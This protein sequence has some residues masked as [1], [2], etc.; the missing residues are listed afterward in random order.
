MKILAYLLLFVLTNYT[1]YSQE[2]SGSFES[3]DKRNLKA[4]EYYKFGNE[5]LYDGDYKGAIIYYDEAIKLSPKVA[6]YYIQRAQAKELAKQETAALTDYEIAIRVDPENPNTYFKRGLLYHN[7]KNYETAIIDF[8]RLIEGESIEETK[9]IIF[10]GSE[11]NKGGDATFNSIVTIDKMRGDVYNARANSLKEMGILDLALQDYDSAITN[12]RESAI[13]LVNRGLLKLE[14]KDTSSAA[15]DFRRALNIEEDNNVALY[16]LSLI[17]DAEERNRLNAKIFKQGQYAQA[18]SKRAFDKYLKNDF[19]GALNDYD[20][21]LILRPNFAEDLMNRGLV[22]IK[23]ER[24][25]EAI[26]DFNASLKYNK[27]LVRNYFHLG[28]IYQ[29]LKDF[30]NAIDHYQLYLSF[31]GSDAGAHYNKGIAEYNSGKNEDACKSLK[32]ALELGEESARKA[33]GSVCK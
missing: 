3:P 33:I 13:F 7:R 16:N 2:N 10:K 23:S 31:D 1:V 19:I 4:D 18:Y 29:V 32:K 6:S 26:D 8:S 27:G 25:I 20:S 11:I 17:A 14:T 22:K 28:N 15:I 21:A 9:A 30:P 24:Y 12:N 5:K